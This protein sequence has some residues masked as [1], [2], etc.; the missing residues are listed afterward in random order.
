MNAQTGGVPR[1][2][3]LTKTSNEPES[4]PI[5]GASFIGDYIEVFAANDHAYVGYNANYRSAPLLNT[6]FPIPQQDNYVTKSH[7]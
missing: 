1:I 2:Q 5:L 6:G 7:L 4:D 3:R